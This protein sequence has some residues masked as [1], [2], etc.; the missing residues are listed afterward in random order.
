[1]DIK[2]NINEAREAADISEEDLDN[3][4]GGV[5][6]TPVGVTLQGVKNLTSTGSGGEE[7]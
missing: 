5:K 7:K 2:D 4:S 1:M 6:V 3:V